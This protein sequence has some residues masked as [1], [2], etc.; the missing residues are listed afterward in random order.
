VGGDGVGVVE[1]VVAAAADHDQVGLG[2]DHLRDPR[3]VGAGRGRAGVAGAVGTE[4][5]LGDPKTLADQRREACGLGRRSRAGRVVVAEERH[6]RSR[7]PG[8]VR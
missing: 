7:L 5:L 6:G 1:D 3:G 8:A 4:V 2:G